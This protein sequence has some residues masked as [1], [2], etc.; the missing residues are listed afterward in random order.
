MKMTGV[1]GWVRWVGGWMGDVG[2]WMGEVGG[3]MGWWRAACLAGWLGGC[4][5]GR[6]FKSQKQE[7]PILVH[8]SSSNL[9]NSSLL[10]A[11]QGDEAMTLSTRTCFNI[12]VRTSCIWKKPPPNDVIS[13]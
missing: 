13:N 8:F 5:I 9:L 10:L 11:R 3:C 12:M 4:V 7:Q 1:G 6:E 2:G